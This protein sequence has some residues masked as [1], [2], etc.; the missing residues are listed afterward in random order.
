MSDLWNVLEPLLLQKPRYLVDP[1]FET[2]TYVQATKIGSEAHRRN[3]LLQ[4]IL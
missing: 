1:E 4:V 2:A 3:F